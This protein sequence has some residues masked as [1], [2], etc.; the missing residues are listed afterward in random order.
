MKKMYLLLFAALICSGNLFA[1]LYGQTFGQTGLVDLEFGNK[2]IITDSYSV[3][4]NMNGHTS[5]LQPDGKFIMAGG[6]SSNQVTLMRYTQNGWLDNSF[7]TNGKSLISSPP[8]S[9]LGGISASLAVQTNGKIIYASGSSGKITLVRLKP[10]G[11]FDSSFGI[12]GISYSPTV[13]LWGSTVGKVIVKADGKIVTAGTGY[14]NVNTPYF[15]VA[16]F[17][18]NGKLDSSFAV[19]G[20]FHYSAGAGGAGH[21]LALLPNDHIIVAGIRF[22]LGVMAGVNLKP[23]GV[24]DSSYG[25]NGVVTC[26]AFLNNKALYCRVSLQNDNKVLLLGCGIWSG[27]RKGIGLG[28]FNINGK[29]DSAFAYLGTLT[30]TFENF[31]DSP[32]G[33]N[34][35]FD[36]TL[37]I[38]GYSNVSSNKFAMMRLKSN[39]TTDTTY[40]RLGKVLTAVP[41]NGGVIDNSF[42][43]PDG[44][45]VLTGSTK[46]NNVYSFVAGRFVVTPNPHYN[47]LKGYTYLDMNSNGVKDST[48]AFAQNI[49]YTIV[50]SALDSITVQSSDGRFLADIL[51]T[52]TYVSNTVLAAPAYYTAPTPVNHITSNTTYFNVDSVAFSIMPLPGVTDVC[53]SLTPCTP[54]RIGG[55][56]LYGISYKN[57]G[58]AISDGTI[59]F[60]KDSNLIFSWA[61]ITPSSVS[62]DTIR[63]NYNNL[64][65]QESGWIVVHMSLPI[66]PAISLGDTVYSTATITPNNTDVNPPNNFAF[67]Q[68]IATYSYDPNNKLESH[69]GK[70]TAAKVAAGE[71]LTYTINFQNTG[72]DYAANVFIRDTLS[73]KL[74]WSTLQMISASHDYQLTMNNGKCFWA[75]NNINLLDSATNPAA[76]QGYLT[77]MVKPK[78][79]VQI[80]DVINNTAAIYFDYNL[81]IFTNTEMTTV[82]AETF[83]LKL[84]SFTARKQDKTNLLNWATAQEINVDHFEIERSTIGRDFNKIGVVISESAVGSSHNYSYTDNNP[85]ASPLS[86]S[87]G[88]G[89]GVRY[90]RLKMIDKDGQ[91]TYSPIRQININHSTLNIAIFPNPAKDK[92]Q[93]QI[94]SDK[95]LALKMDI[96][97]Q[98]GK[99]VL[100]SNVST[101]EGIILRSINISA[102]QSGMYFLRVTSGESEQT[103]IKFEKL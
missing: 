31:G 95:R 88:E 87:V 82:V 43:Q 55:N 84:L 15:E 51:D 39:G 47:T 2:G 54:A 60:I 97:T 78:A 100:S 72:N 75:F 93:L 29:P 38:S 34:E 74:D 99:V 89:P 22:P 86:N 1:Q 49:K 68:Q 71:Y 48:E 66:P 42:M 23:N 28:R 63:W 9:N 12:N 85:F 91:F 73:N 7:G 94:D 83:P 19:N 35:Q 17:L 14:Y 56:V 79:N 77:Y 65:P 57:I 11:T 101:T 4:A 44:K 36:G 45:I 64:I 81:P 24:I 27:N 52:G 13:A 103:V 61:T 8:G 10:N 18:P 67:L 90:Y 76:S 53:I 50:K 25:T 16:Q 80:G 32:Q 58:T 69:G 33:V 102:L 30:T 40:G 5:V 26:Q 92:L 62:G 37:V 70:I 59:E 98:D 3:T 21:S 41:G 96:I 46:L 6:N 20:F